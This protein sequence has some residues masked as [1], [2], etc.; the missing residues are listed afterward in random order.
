[1]L[2]KDLKTL[3]NKLPEGVSQEQFDEL[4]VMFSHDEDFYIPSV[5]NSGFIEFGDPCDS[6]GNPIED[7]KY[8]NI[9]AF[10]LIAEE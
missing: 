9:S 8:K 5:E 6:K 10:A 7:D 1:M 2:V 4:T 3:L